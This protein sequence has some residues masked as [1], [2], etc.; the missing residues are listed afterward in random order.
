MPAETRARC[1]DAAYAD[2]VALIERYVGNPDAQFELR[3]AVI[4]YGKQEAFQGID[5]ALN[6]KAAAAHAFIETAPLAR[7][8]SEQPATPVSFAGPLRCRCTTDQRPLPCPGSDRCG[9]RCARITPTGFVG[10]EQ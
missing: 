3:R 1:S 7:D 8:A 2:V 6:A 5:D 4:E 9:Y 10:R